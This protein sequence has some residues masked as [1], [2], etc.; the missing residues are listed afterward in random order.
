[1]AD[2]TGDANSKRVFVSYKEILVSEDSLTAAE[3]LT[4]AGF[5]PAAYELSLSDTGERMNYDRELKI[6]DGM[7]MEASVKS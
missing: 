4:K 3:I 2:I 1:M 7:K 6:K 5:N